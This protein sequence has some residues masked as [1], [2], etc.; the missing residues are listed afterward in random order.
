MKYVKGF[1]KKALLTGVDYVARR[2]GRGIADRVIS[3]AKKI[4]GAMYFNTVGKYKRKGA[5][6]GALTD[7]RNSA[8]IP[9]RR[10]IP[11]RWRKFVNKV[12]SAVQAVQ[13]RCVYSSVGKGQTTG[14]DDAQQWS[15]A[16]FADLNT[17]ATADI[18]NCFK[19]A[20]GLAAVADADKYKL[21]INRVYSQFQINTFSGGN[22]SQIDLYLVVCRQDVDDFGTPLGQVTEYFQ[23][24]TSIGVTSVS[25]PNVDLFMIPNFTRMFKILKTYKF[26][27]DTGKTIRVEHSFAVNRYIKGK[28][29]EDVQMLKGLTHGWIYRIRGPPAGG[30]A[31]N[32]G[33]GAISSNYAI[34]TRINYQTVTSTSTDTVGQ[35]K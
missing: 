22:G 11:K 2:T 7:Q 25:D 24:M 34:Q 17:S 30:T 19:D 15:G 20:Y 26:L 27:I 9:A 23:D 18:W 14:A 4:G 6:R 12:N 29:L 31:G 1:A 13:P 32:A 28:D 35:T 21:F 10:R 3:G 8:V 5:L 16:W 33:L